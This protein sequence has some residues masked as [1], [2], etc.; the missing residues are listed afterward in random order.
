MAP[1]SSQFD[2]EFE[3]AAVIGADGSDLTPAQAARH[4]A[5]YVLYCDWSSP[6][7]QLVEKE[8]GIALG[9]AKDGAIS[10]G[11]HVIDAQGARTLRH[12]VPDLTMRSDLR[13]D[14]GDHEIHLLHPGF[15]AHTDGDLVVWLPADRV[16]FAGDLLFPGLSPLAVAGRPSGMLRALDW[17]ESFEPPVV[18][19]GHGPVV[20]ARDLDQVLD[21]PRRYPHPPAGP[22]RTQLQATPLAVAR[23]TDL[24]EFA[25]LREHERLVLNLHAAYAELTEAKV[26]RRQA[27]SDAV[28]YR[29]GPMMSKA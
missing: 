29:G 25:T 9:K 21:V 23:S 26:D 10:L 22:P 17:I 15:P 14:P 2:F 24:G 5:G 7:I 18:I 6:D 1:G 19:A 3:I 8:M 16:L 13:L 20:P 28:D 12:R 4:I 11:P 27:L